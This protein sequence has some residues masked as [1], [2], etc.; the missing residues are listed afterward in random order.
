MSFGSRVGG[1]GVGVG[2]GGLD[3]GTDGQAGFRES[4][5]RVTRV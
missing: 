3:S 2:V 5:I 4:R 1:S